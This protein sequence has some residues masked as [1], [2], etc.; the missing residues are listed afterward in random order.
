MREAFF[1]LPLADG[2]DA[3]ALDLHDGGAGVEI[4]IVDAAQRAAVQ[5]I[6]EIRAKAL[7][8]EVV[9]AAAHLLVRGEG[10]L[11]GAVGEG[12]G[13]GL[14]C[15]GH[16]LRDARLIVRAQEGGSGR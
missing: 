16:D 10:D 3:Q 15:K 11:D 2:M 5:G 8:V 1:I 7:H 13:H 4:F 6:G 12:L 14:G 9:H